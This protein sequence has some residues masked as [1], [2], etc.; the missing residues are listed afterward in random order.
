MRRWKHGSLDEVAP[1]LWRRCWGVRLAQS[2]AVLIESSTSFPTGPAAGRVRRV[3]GEAK[4]RSRQSTE[5]RTES[6]VRVGGP[7]RRHSRRGT[8]RV[9]KLFRRPRLPSK[10]PEMGTSVSPHVVRELA[11]RRGDL[12]LHKIARGRGR[13]PVARSRGSVSAHR[14][15]GQS[16]SSRE[17]RY[18]PRG[19]QGQG[20]A[21]RATLSEGPRVDAAGVPGIRP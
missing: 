1:C 6:E 12:A 13:R 15:E 21:S 7:H 17:A 2:N 11:G 8:E 16:T 4:K 9:D 5:A 3:G 10:S 18:F 20:R 19:Y 14:L